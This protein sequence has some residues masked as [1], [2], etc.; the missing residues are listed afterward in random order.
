M[1]KQ[2]YKVHTNCTKDLILLSRW[3][4][5]LNGLV[6]P[7]PKKPT[8]NP[9]TNNCSGNLLKILGLCYV[10]LEKQTHFHIEHTYCTRFS[11]TI[12]DC[13]K[14][15]QQGQTKSLSWNQTLILFSLK[16]FLF[17][18]KYKVNT[19]WWSSTFICW[20]LMKTN[21]FKW[22]AKMNRKEQLFELKRK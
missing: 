21:T 4:S 13:N 1:Q 11:H 16:W 20:Q 8:K 3:S 14:N 7:P 19:C 17:S 22:L 5:Q 2:F 10:W 6:P 18:F 12:V 9:K 15:Q